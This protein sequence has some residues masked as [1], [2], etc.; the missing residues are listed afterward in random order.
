MPSRPPGGKFK[1]AQGNRTRK[2]KPKYPRPKYSPRMEALISG[3][4]PITDLDEEEIMRGQ[5]R[6]KDGTFRGRAHD[7]VPRQFY[8][9]LKA[10]QMRLWQM[11]VDAQFQPALDALLGLVTGSKVSH[12]A[13]YK[14]AVFLMERAGGKTPD[15]VEVKATLKKWEEGIEGLFYDDGKEASDGDS[16]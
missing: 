5:L 13:K 7:M 12:D 15:K 3:E 1:D 11:K 8:D 4:L 9:A 2:T 6:S 14:A 10:E 16:E